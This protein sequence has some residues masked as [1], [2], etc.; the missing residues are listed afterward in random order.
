MSE[1]QQLDD[2][3]RKVHPL[4]SL[5]AGQD[6]DGRG[7][8]LAV[9]GSRLVS[10][11]IRLTGEGALRVGAG[12]VQL[13]T[14]AEATTCLGVQF[15]EAATIG[16]A[17]GTDG[18]IAST[19]GRAIKSNLA[20]CDALVVG[21]GMADRGTSCGLIEEISTLLD[22]D[23]SAVLDAGALTGCR[24]R[25]GALDKI[26][27]RLV[28]TPHHGELARLLNCDRDKVDAAPLRFARTAADTYGAVVVLKDSRTFIVE[29][30]GRALSFE[31]NVPGLGT[32]GSGDVLAGILGGLLARGLA[33]FEA[34]A[35]AVWL[36]AEAGREASKRI[37]VIGFLARELL[38]SLPRLVESSSTVDG[39]APGDA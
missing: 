6:K 18:E 17:T 27:A 32:A 2:G 5:S 4:P 23:A 7:R 12:K 22:P 9:G 24:H 10:G 8:V 14:T 30:G 11:A 13:A 29:P 19:A 36:H 35:W 34:A 39:S 33:N 25:P 26:N 20:S 38:P 37:G 31:A 1:L 21:P 28:M 16:L 3:W 15:P